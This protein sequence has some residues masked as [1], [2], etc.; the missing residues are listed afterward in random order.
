MYS[1]SK[2]QAQRGKVKVKFKVFLRSCSLLRLI[3]SV[4]LT[5]SFKD[6][7]RLE[8]DLELGQ[9]EEEQFTPTVAYQQG[10]VVSVKGGE[11]GD[12]LDPTDVEEDESGG[13]LTHEVGVGQ[14]RISGPVHQRIRLERNR[15]SRF[16]FFQS[17]K[18]LC[19]RHEAC[20]INGTR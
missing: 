18:G 12:H 3:S 8:G 15:E 9:A 1:L 13:H 4:D 16:R 20:V 19:C 7:S 2:R 11:G 5:L 10:L 14:R 17:S 6:G